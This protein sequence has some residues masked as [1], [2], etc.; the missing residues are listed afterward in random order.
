MEKEFADVIFET[1]LLAIKKSEIEKE[2]F[3]DFNFFKNTA[4]DCFRKG[5]SIYDST[6]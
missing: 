6:W 4:Y 2:F 5:L 3:N 1:S